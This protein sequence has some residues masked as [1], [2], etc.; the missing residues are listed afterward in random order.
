MASWEENAAGLRWHDP[1]LR[2]EDKES[3]LACLGAWSCLGLSNFS[4]LGTW[5]CGGGWLERHA[6]QIC[7]S[8][9][10]VRIKP[11]PRPRP[12]PLFCLYFA[13]LTPQRSAGG[14]K[15]GACFSPTSAPFQ[16]VLG[17]VCHRRQGSLE[18]SQQPAEVAS[19]QVQLG[20]Q[21]F[22]STS[23]SAGFLPLRGKTLGAKG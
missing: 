1:E 5:T 22:E 19:S 9:N 2:S 13:S 17:S 15:E 16:R 21:L 14:G 12:R 3:E 4:V 6:L 8:V 18:P 11:A 23:D 10:A 20:K 7:L